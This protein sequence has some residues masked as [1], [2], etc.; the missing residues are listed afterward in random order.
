MWIRE[1]R[2]APFATAVIT[3]GAK[4]LSAKMLAELQSTDFNVQ[5]TTGQA[6]L[7]FPPKE[8]FVGMC[9]SVPVWLIGIF[10]IDRVTTYNIAIDERI[11]TMF[12]SRLF[13]PGETQPQDALLR[14]LT[15][16]SIPAHVR[17][18]FPG[19]AQ[20]DAIEVPCADTY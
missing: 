8:G 7:C 19:A 13:E 1:L 14:L 10:A 2:R 11:V 20:L 18:M 15:S 9:L 3:G 16:T 6:R 12:Y 5:D 4:S 17:T